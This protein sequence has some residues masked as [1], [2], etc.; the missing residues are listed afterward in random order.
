MVP[1]EL[2]RGHSWS[3]AFVLLHEAQNAT[4][5]K[6]LLLLIGIGKGSKRV[7]S[8]ETR[9]DLPTGSGLSTIPR[10]IGTNITLG[11]GPS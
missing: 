2:V 7:V 6:L 1:F 10:M 8:G 11:A 5:E 4:N 3:D 9:S